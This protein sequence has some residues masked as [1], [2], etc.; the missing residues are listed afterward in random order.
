MKF[1]QQLGETDTLKPFTISEET[2][3]L[4]TSGIHKKN[5]PNSFLFYSCHKFPNSTWLWPDH[6]A[7]IWGNILRLRTIFLV[8]GSVQNVQRYL[9]I[10]TSALHKNEP[11]WSPPRAWESHLKLSI[12]N[13]KEKRI[14]RESNP[15]SKRVLSLQ[16]P[17][18]IEMYF[19]FLDFKV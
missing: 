4:S 13:M 2:E 15:L 12:G 5:L 16:H 3:S 6:W 7:H 1:D 8:I 18:H 11:L 19:C 17:R 9:N 14:K 10:T